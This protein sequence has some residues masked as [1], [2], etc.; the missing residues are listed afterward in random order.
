LVF[1]HCHMDHHSLS[2]GF[3]LNV[4]CLFDT[5]GGVVIFLIFPLDNRRIP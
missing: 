4:C 3:R 5:L 1:D 2:F